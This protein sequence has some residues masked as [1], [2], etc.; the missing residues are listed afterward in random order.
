MYFCIRLFCAPS[1]L[2][3]LSV[4]AIVSWKFFWDSFPLNSFWSNK[5]GQSTGSLGSVEIKFKWR[6]DLVWDPSTCS[7][8]V[9]NFCHR[10]CCSCKMNKSFSKKF[11][12]TSFLTLV[13]IIVHICRKSLNWK[14]VIFA[15]CVLNF[16]GF[17]KFWTGNSRVHHGHPWPRVKSPNGKKNNFPITPNTHQKTSKS[18]KKFPKTTKIFSRKTNFLDYS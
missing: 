6:P 3:N 18:P 11:S 17:E 4:I 5:R 9:R 15:F 12:N 16:F 1:K 13:G 8:I 10:W 2:H 7:C 14:T